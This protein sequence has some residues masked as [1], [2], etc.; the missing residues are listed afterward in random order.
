MKKV[1]LV[2]VLLAVCTVS[3]TWMGSL[4][5]AGDAEPT[6]STIGAPGT[7][8]GAEAG[9]NIEAGLWRG[10]KA[11]F[12]DI[13]LL[14]LFWGDLRRGYA[15]TQPIPYSHKV[16]AGDL[17]IECQYCHSGVHKAQYA[18]IPSTEACMGCHN[19]V[20][21]DRPN[22]QALKEYADAG[23]SVPWEPVHNL[24][25]HVYFTHERHV[26]AGV[27]CQTCHGMVQDMEVVEKVASMKM[28]FCV[29]CHRENGASI[30]CAVCH[31]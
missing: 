4:A 31:Q 20:R 19:V 15:P 13:K 12:S 17:G 18:T 22:I 11:V 25:E 24:P 30:D 23:K 6:Q 26:K 1:V 16:H 3:L 5:Y 9:P 14:D 29:S 21:T 28:G 7:Q 27:S 10:G 8:T 2:V